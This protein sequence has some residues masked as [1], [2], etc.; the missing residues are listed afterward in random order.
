[1]KNLA[2]LLA[3]LLHSVPAQA[4]G[5]CGNY[6]EMIKTLKSRYGE[7]SQ[8]KGI[9]AEAY[10][11][12]IFTGPETFTVLRTDTNSVSCIIA[13]GRGWQT[14]PKSLGEDT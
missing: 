14:A 9:Q 5:M 6:T 13:A 8:G 4:Q 11:I 1:M 10:L 2:A 7:I 12:E 3:I